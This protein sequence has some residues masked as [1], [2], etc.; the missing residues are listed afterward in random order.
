MT[1]AQ[2]DTAYRAFCRRRQ[3]RSFWLEFASGQQLLVSHPEAIVDKGLLYYM[4]CPDGTQ[5]LFAVESVVRMFDL[6]TA[7]PN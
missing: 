5:V 2:F 3:F 1:K 4:R 6:P 7:A